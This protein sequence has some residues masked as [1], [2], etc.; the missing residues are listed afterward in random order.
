MHITRRSFLASSCS[1]AVLPGT[2]GGDFSRAGGYRAVVQIEL[3]GGNDAFNTVVPLARAQHDLY[4]EWRRHLSLERDSLLPLT[5]QDGAPTLGLHPALTGIHAMY[6]KGCITVLAG[7]G[8]LLEAYGPQSAADGRMRLPHDL[9]AHRAQSAYWQGMFCSIPMDPCDSVPTQDS[10]V[11]ERY[12]V[13]LTRLSVAAPRGLPWRAQSPR[14]GQFPETHCPL[15]QALDAATEIIAR[16]RCDPRAR[17]LIKVRQEGWDHHRHALIL[18]ARALRSLDAAMVRLHAWLHRETAPDEIA[19]MTASEFGR[20][21]EP[22]GSGSNHG[23]SGHHFLMHGPRQSGRICGH[24]PDLSP[25]GPLHVG[26]GVFA[27][28]LAVNAVGAE[29]VHW[30]GLN[31]SQPDDRSLSKSSR[32]NA[33]LI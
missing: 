1:L 15:A 9:F 26:H 21:L 12:D 18:H 2:A 5:T 31:A 20:A 16:R 8:P 4:R 27:P 29:L 24:Y 23:W 19:V 10:L 11:G 6:L 14:N 25:D 3:G 17:D 22:D 30:L 7:V 32:N 13:Q 28:T 33:D